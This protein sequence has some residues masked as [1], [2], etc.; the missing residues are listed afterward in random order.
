MGNP[1]LGEI[2]LFAGDFAPRNYVMCNG[3]MMAISQ[4][5]A[6]YSLLNTY[7]GG[8]GVTTYA[9]PDFRGRVPM[10]FGQGFGLT[11]KFI[12]QR[13]GQET[14][15]LKTSELP[16]HNHTLVTTGDIGNSMDPSG[17]YWAKSGTVVYSTDVSSLEALAD[18]DGE[19][20]IS[21]TGGDQPHEN[22]QPLLTINF[23]MAVAG[24]YPSRN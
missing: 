4:N 22:R 11:R 3:G 5:P 10:H 2:K 6:L 24:D 13:G 16:V 15:T 23:I 19:A 21:N 18:K 20:T 17:N 8:D 7:Y 1:F 14:V 9:V 12:G